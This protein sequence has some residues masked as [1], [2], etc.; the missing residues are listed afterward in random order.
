[1]RLCKE[2]VL[3]NG[4]LLP[5]A[6][7]IDARKRQVLWYSENGANLLKVFSCEQVPIAA[8]LCRFGDADNAYAKQQ[9]VAIL[10][11]PVL[12]RLH[13][14]TGDSFDI[15]LP[16]PMSAL[17]SIPSGL[18]FYREYTDNEDRIITGIG[19][20]KNTK[21]NRM[22]FSP[23][24][25]TTK[26]EEKVIPIMFVLSNP[27][28]FLS[29][30]SICTNSS[31]FDAK[32][33]L[34]VTSGQS[35]LGFSYIHNPS[36]P[37][38][39]ATPL[40]SSPSKL[41][42][43]FEDNIVNIHGKYVC[44]IAKD[45]SGNISLWSIETLSVES[46]VDMTAASL[47]KSASSLGKSMTVVMDTT[48]YATA[49]NTSGV[50]SASANSIGSMGAISRKVKSYSPNI[51][52]PA[53]PQNQFS[54]ISGFAGS[55]TNPLDALTTLLGSGY[56]QKESGNILRTGSPNI[57]SY[58]NGRSTPT[59]FG[60]STP[61]GDILA[62]ASINQSGSSPSVGAM[63][64]DKDVTSER[65]TYTSAVN[66][67]ISQ[68]ELDPSFC[69]VLRGTYSIE[70]SGL[71]PSFNKI[72]P[73]DIKCVFID[74]IDDSNVLLL[75]LHHVSG[76][77]QTL[78][79]NR[80]SQ[81]L[82]LTRQN[83]T[84]YSQQAS[85]SS[86]SIS[87]VAIAHATVP[88]GISA[89]YSLPFSLL[90]DQLN[91][92]TRLSYMLGTK[93]LYST[94]LEWIDDLTASVETVGAAS[95]VS[96]S[97]LHGGQ[98]RYISLHC[99]ES[100]VVLSLPSTLF[101]NIA[102]CNQDVAVML[103]ETVKGNQTMTIPV[104][105]ILALMIYVETNAGDE[106]V[107]PCLLYSLFL[108]DSCELPNRFSRS[109]HEFILSTRN[110][111]NAEGGALIGAVMFDMLHS[112]WEDLVLRSSR[113]SAM[114]HLGTVLRSF[115]T[116]T[117]CSGS[118]ELSAIA[119]EYCNH[120]SRTLS[121]HT[122][123]NP[124]TNYQCCGVWKPFTCCSIVPDATSWLCSAISALHNSNVAP[125]FPFP[126]I[127]Q[128]I[129]YTKSYQ[130]LRFCYN[131]MQE[132]VNEMRRSNH[133]NHPVN[134]AFTLANSYVHHSHGDIL[135]LELLPIE[136]K[137]VVEMALFQC[138]TM[139][140]NQ[141]V[142]VNIHGKADNIGHWPDNILAYIGRPD[143]CRNTSNKLRVNSNVGEKKQSAQPVTAVVQSDGLADVESAAH[144]L[145][146]G[147]DDRVHEVCRMLR[148]SKH[149][150][151]RVERTPENS[152]LEHRSK[153]QMRLLTLCRR[154][155]AACVGRGMLTMGSLEPLM[156]ES[157][158]IPTLMLAGRVPPQNIII[159]LET[160]HAPSE[161]TLWP[162]FHN[163]V[164][165]GLR[166]GPAERRGFKQAGFGNN[167][168]VRV[169]RNWIIYNRTAYVGNEAAHAGF[170]LALGLQGYLNV[171]SVTDICDY[172]TQGHEPTTVA[173]LIGMAA[174]KVGSADT[175]LSKTLCLHLPALLPPRINCDIEIS[176][177]VQTAALTGLG[178]LHAGSGHRLMTE[179]LLAEISRKP[180]SDCCETREA[181]ALS[182]SWALGMVLLAKGSKNIELGIGTAGNIPSEGLSGLADLHIEDR[183]FQHIVGG[184]RPTESHL[185]P[186]ASL[187]ADANSKS[188]RILE[189][190]DINVNVTAPGAT[191]ALAMIYI[192]S[193]NLEIARRLALPVTSFDIDAIRPDLLLFR[194]MSICLVMWDNVEP[195]EMWIENQVPECIT[196]VL[197]SAPT[198]PVAIPYKKNNGSDNKLSPKSALGAYL[199]IVTG[200]CIGIGLVHAGT[201]NESA[202][203][204]ILAKLKVLQCLRDNKLSKAVQFQNLSLDKA[205]KPLIEM[206]VSCTAVALS[207]VMAGTGDLACLRIFREL[208]W[209]VE[210]VNYGSHM[211]IGMAIGMLFLAG[212]NASLR[213]DPFSISC[214]LLSICPRFPMRTADNQYH[215]QPLRHMYV[216]AAESRAL[217]TVDIDSG[218]S[219]PLNVTVEM[220]DGTTLA[221]R[222]PCLVPELTTIK[223]VVILSEE[224][225]D[226][227]YSKRFSFTRNH[228]DE[229]LT[230]LPPLFVK[231][232]AAISV[233]NSDEVLMEK[234]ALNSFLHVICSSMQQE[235][236]KGSGIKDV[237][238]QSP[239]IM[240]IIYK[241]MK[242]V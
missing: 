97:S 201:S 22:S 61:V 116:D 220:N 103:L 229:R 136:L 101:G 38:V 210:D 98:N 64:I 41:G 10:I 240:S 179:F 80:K 96:I 1:M 52:N 198:K 2:A 166:V 44:T 92:V 160:T 115:L 84:I 40:P 155:F 33:K 231:R 143:L 27:L 47:D 37:S 94:E 224:N 200:Y 57:F 165:A 172:L 113:V 99:Q 63:S 85:S 75:H 19:S 171:L 138:K 208:R 49:M 216:L 66:A 72:Y 219:V 53:N 222:A 241:S 133:F 82:Q 131:I 184:K 130:S 123:Y 227:Y 215:L 91:S 158:P 238:S 105:N 88:I 187:L 217:R 205:M 25:V 102:Y 17:Y 183:L 4:T 45:G 170:L 34:D 213:R 218:V 173:L 147:E 142:S 212:G 235:A 154:T 111:C 29:P 81:S 70:K 132:C 193:N 79:Y 69:L 236:L 15:L 191:I 13:P 67:V 129:C 202:K 237:L 228:E 139:N 149:I 74:K 234:A 175:L 12:L 221:M 195:S 86:T 31:E 182:V 239:H 18:L 76:I 9:A 135:A 36:K 78:E 211:S 106:H 126:N 178:L 156:A 108:D 199:C 23:T 157:L 177:I 43:T 230:S 39:L 7:M 127:V 148:S 20:P 6:L 16:H 83:H 162:E 28:S 226:Q 153:L 223:S 186:L 54:S 209:K 55:A 65:I 242:E 180:T 87:C 32:D 89:P 164:A 107:I 203:A 59:L 58:N 30:V 93:L 46:T 122:P 194:A 119:T 104:E 112:C 118:A 185:F 167:V 137:Y 169:T 152:D 134:F 232:K 206:C 151:L 73:S 24:S 48:G 109:I 56:Q 77:A 62:Q 100:Q 110:V 14:P 8:C 121:Q 150:Y 120:Y 204:T 188:S 159:A 124:L 90:L 95:P 35:A 225:K 163:G 60:R 144:Q 50:S 140:G 181:M 51:F 174:A 128:S 146:F 207:Y 233:S 190:E 189:G 197:Y 21:Y 141:N 71:F 11:S 192:K 42:K 125:A 161:L 168:P 117:F 145:R 196:S 5:D 3:E 26:N 214:L 68:P 114:T 176:P